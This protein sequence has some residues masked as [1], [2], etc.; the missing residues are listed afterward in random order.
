MIMFLLEKVS[1]FVFVPT[2]GFPRHVPYSTSARTDHS[3]TLSVSS[4]RVLHS[5][6]SSRIS[7]SMFDID[8]FDSTT[9]TTVVDVDYQTE[10]PTTLLKRS[11]VVS[12][13]QELRHKYGYLINPLLVP[14]TTQ[15]ELLDAIMELED[16]FVNPSSS[17]PSTV[18]RE[19]VITSLLPGDW[20]LICTIPILNNNN[21][22][23]ASSTDLPSLFENEFLQNLFPNTLPIASLT[24]K[25]FTVTQR[26]RCMD[27][28]DTATI[29]RVDHVIE[30][31]PPNRVS[32]ILNNNN[33]NDAS[34]S[35][36]WFNNININPFEVKETKVI[37]V[38][39]AEVIEESNNMDTNTKARN[40]K[41]VKVRLNL[42]SVVNNIAGT[43]G[44]LDPNGSD[45][46]SLNVPQL[47]FI[48]KN[49]PE[50]ND[51]LG[52]SFR[53]TYVDEEYRI[54][55]SDLLLSLGGGNA[56]GTNKPQQVRIFQKRRSRTTVFQQENKD[57]M[58]DVDDIAIDIE[59]PSD[60]E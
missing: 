14:R 42:K 44:T 26:I 5:S 32:D 45:I 16:D 50:L 40:E 8:D 3:P 52:G 34:S 55:R 4:W 15:R 24:N 18:T 47:D 53:T 41:K 1:S 60:V 10:P 37:L 43:G 13:A 38:H 17:P 29:N 27:E 39:D 49:Y 51:A 21:N 9:D 58:T 46:L 19:D 57:D 31:K 48:Q 36:S 7:S 30:V 59:P 56:D 54:S 28:Y 23:Q 12:M 22:N 2:S 20:D 6:S 25:F 35:S 33:S 11:N